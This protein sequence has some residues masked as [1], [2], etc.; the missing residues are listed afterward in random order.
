MV[1]KE[2]FAALDALE[3]EKNIKKEYFIEA[4]ETGLTA[5]YKKTY[6][7]AKSAE[8][9]L[10]PEK[11]M[12]KIYS[13]KT[14][15]EEVADADKEI[16]LADAKAI[17][18]TYKVGDVVSQEENPKEFGRIPSQTV[19]HVIMQKLKEATRAQEYSILSDK[20]GTLISAIIMREEN[21][22]YYLNMGG[23]DA[24]GVLN[25]KEVI[26]GERLTVGSRIKVYVRKIVESTRGTQIQVSRTNPNFVKRLFELDVPEIQNGDVIINSIAREAGYRTKIAVSSTNPQCDPVGA[27]VG[28]KGSRVNSIVS[29]ISGEKIDI[30]PYSDDPSEFIANALSPAKVISVTIDELAKSSVVIVPNDKLSLAIGK[31]GLNVRLAVKLTGWKMD[32]KSEA[33]AQEKPTEEISEIQAD[34]ADLFGDISD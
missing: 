6:G 14:V 1:S 13:Y 9:K 33:N 18:R 22:A 32:V 29:E 26:P 15:V 7:E 5:A 31:D 16:S 8:V 23:M 19:K 21:G 11:N 27:C 28:N 2:F 10:F 12:I 20:E 4:L 3:K 25:E 30:I 34:D 17:K 24:E